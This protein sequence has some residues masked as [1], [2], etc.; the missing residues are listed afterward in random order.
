MRVIIVKLIAPLRIQSEDEWGD[1]GL[2]L[3]FGPTRYDRP[4]TVLLFGQTA[5]LWCSFIMVRP[6]KIIRSKT[7]NQTNQLVHGL[8]GSFI[9][10]G[11]PPVRRVKSAHSDRIKEQTHRATHSISSSSITPT[12]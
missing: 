6:D 2:V 9:T 5:G 8:H 1:L 10:T 11:D 4:K 12:C 7:T 3:L